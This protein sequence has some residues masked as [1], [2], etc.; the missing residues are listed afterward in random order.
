MGWRVTVGIFTFSSFFHGSHAPL[1][2]AA[3]GEG[4]VPHTPGSTVAWLT[5]KQACAPSGDPAEGAHDLC[6]PPESQGHGEDPPHSP[7]G[8]SPGSPSP[9]ILFLYREGADREPTLDTSSH[10]GGNL[11][12]ISPK[13]MGKLRHGE[14]ETSARVRRQ[15]DAPPECSPCLSLSL[16]LTCPFVSGA[17]APPTEQASVKRAGALG[18]GGECSGCPILASKVGRGAQ[19]S[20]RSRE[21]RWGS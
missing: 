6:R 21:T 10:P 8:A 9:P 16:R 2:A 14:A 15:M 7:Q 12:S 19:P 20:P 11:D 13:Q 3:A 4:H 18:A 1:T 5:Q 17:S